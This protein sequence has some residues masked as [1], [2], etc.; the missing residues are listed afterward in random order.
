MNGAELMIKFKEVFPEANVFT[1]PTTYRCSQAVTQAGNRIASKIDNT[2]INTAN[3]NDGDVT[4]LPM[5][6]SQADEAGEVSRMAIDYFKNTDKSIRILYR[7]NAQSLMFQL[8][9]I[10]NNIPYSINQARSIFNT[11]EGRLAMAACSLV[12]DYDDASIA[13]KANIIN[14]IKT[15]LSTRRQVYYAMAEMKK[16]KTDI[17]SGQ[18]DGRY[19]DLYDELTSLREHLAFM[20]K[21]GLI[22]ASIAEMKDVAELSD[23]AVD[24]LR[25]IAEFIKEC[26]TMQEVQI[27]IDEISRPRNVSK[28]ERVIS[29][30]T[31][32]GSKGMEADIV[33]LTGVVDGVMPSTFGLDDEEINL[34]YVGVTRA[35]DKLYLSNFASFGNKNYSGTQYLQMV[36]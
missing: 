22:V 26:N 31:I 33:F 4:V 18:L 24:N 3:K 10:K 19:D 27:M 23:S 12:F 15:I 5:F 13:E 16:T 14:N 20:E 7:N 32:H 28:N 2:S 29:L 25:G 9:L 6:D 1:L 34:M 8:Y 21:P 30:S 11:K 36:Q 17:M 35:R